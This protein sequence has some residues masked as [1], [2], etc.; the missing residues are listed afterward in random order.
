[1][2]GKGR[3]PVDDPVRRFWVIRLLIVAI[4]LLAVPTMLSVPAFLA[5]APVRVGE[6]SPRTVFAPT[7]IRV[8]DPE[9]TERAR[10]EEA[11]AVQP[12]YDLDRQAQTEVVAQVRDWFALVRSVREP[13]EPET[14]EEDGEPVEAPSPTASEQ[15]EALENRLPM[16]DD[17]GI[18]ALVNMT[19][20]R[21]DRLASETIEIAQQLARQRIRDD[22]L[23]NILDRELPTEIGLRD[24]SPSVGEQVVEPMIR[25]A[26][27]PTVSVDETATA[28]ARRDAALSVSEV[29]R[30]FPAGSVIIS[31]GETATPAQV[32]ALE[33]A[34]LAGADP[35]WELLRAVVVVAIAI[36]VI[37]LF[38]RVYHPGIWRSNR[39][40]LLLAVLFVFYAIIL[41]AVAGG[42]SRQDIWLYAVP[43]G[44]LAMLA[45]VLLRPMVGL[46]S[47]IPVT[48]LTAFVVP[49]SPGVIAFSAAVTLVSVPFATRLSARGDLRRATLLAAAAHIVLAGLFAAV[50]AGI[51]SVPLALLAGAVHGVATAVIVLGGLPFLE[52]AFGI[53]TATSLI[54]LADRNHPL[55]RELE[56]KALGSYNHSIIV[57]TLVE[58]ACRSIDADPLLGSV[59]ALYHD[60]GKVRRPYFFVENQFGIRNPHDDLQPRISAQVIHKH[61]DDGIE[62]AQTYHLPAEVVDGIA[63]HHGTTLVTYFYLEAV[64]DASPDEK[65][66]EDDFRYKGRKPRTK[67]TAVLMLAD[68]CE[69]ASRA[70]AQNDRNLT[71]DQLVDLVEALLADRVDDGQL[72]E[73]P[74]TFQ[75]LAVVKDSFIETLVGVYHPRVTYPSDGDRPPTASQRPRDT[76]VDGDGQDVA[77]SLLDAPALEVTTPRTREPQS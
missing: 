7:L 46:L 70:A 2:L 5:D 42:V 57:A 30:S 55:L 56:Q 52:S 48:L 6:P 73:S 69:A 58:R 40:L 71:R 31:T 43:A 59:C 38:L 33:R 32:A 76:P 17:E 53:V 22:E 24:I 9:A 1:V 3:A 39:D 44:A 41:G 75:D 60:I 72:D 62:M 47:A 8:D 19:D 66:D 21:L 45:T 61:V 15:I 74:L 20:S 65:V 36:A 18:R 51:Q 10:R 12:I 68:C 49:E 54:D 25:A 37:S 63:T 28:R 50:F 77:G 13:A 23:A 29:T 4:V 16:L 27:R 11:E 26:M 35:R 64:R 67:E 14:R 34:G